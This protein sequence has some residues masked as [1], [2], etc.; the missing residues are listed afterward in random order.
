MGVRNASVGELNAGEGDVVKSGVGHASLVDVAAVGQLHRALFSTLVL[1]DV[2][3]AAIQKG[4]HWVRVE[5][6]QVPVTRTG[7][8]AW[9]PGRRL[10]SLTF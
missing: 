2:L 5:E 1:L 3:V 4:C 8:M 7:G 10:P 6:I 9:K